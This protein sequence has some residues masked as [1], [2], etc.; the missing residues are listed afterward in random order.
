MKSLSSIL[1]LLLISILIFE[2]CRKDEFTTDKSA[3]LAFSTDT[4]YFDTILTTV[5]SI[6]KRFKIYNP[7]DQNIVISELYLGG[8]TN[9]PYRLNVDGVKGNTHKEIEIRRKDSLYVFVEVT[10]DPLNSNSPLIVCD[11]VICI[12]NGN[13]QNVKL[14]SYGQDVHLLSNETINTQTWTADKPYLIAKS[15]ALDSGQVLTIEP[16]THIF[17]NYNQALFIYGKLIAKGTYE[18]PIVFRGARF[19]ERYENAAGQWGGIYFDPMS[20]N[21]LLEYVNIRNANAGLQIGYPESKEGPT[22]EITNCKILNS[23]SYAMI[24][25]NATVKSY[26]TIIADCGQAMFLILMG[27]EYNLYHLTGSNISAFYPGDDYWKR[28]TP[29][30]IATNFYRFYEWNDYYQYENKVFT[31]DLNLNFYNSIIYGSLKNEVG[32]Y[33][34]SVVA[35]HYKFDH[36]ILKNQKDSFEYVKDDEDVYMKYDDISMF[37]A[38]K[39]NKGPKFKND[40]LSK[41]EYIFDLDSLSSAIDSADIQLIMGIPQLQSDYAGKSR[42]KDGKPDM[43]ALERNE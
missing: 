40:S 33:D 11:S 42:I 2:S 25:Y 10:I 27:G 31:N 41:G 24:A 34:T 7:N 36:C 13:E 18:N 37:N 39:L 29:S 19:D 8:G 30:L 5:G 14:L 9:S 20:K 15:I 38:L 12:T 21:N 16:G 28:S 3:K 4:V 17:L 23:A 1:F 35:F 32:F 6:T 26:N 43:G 22:I